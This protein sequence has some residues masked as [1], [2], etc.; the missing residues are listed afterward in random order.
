MIKKILAAALAAVCLIGTG[1][2][3]YKQM[4]IE[5]GETKALYFLFQ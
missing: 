4:P 5:T 1:C 2:D 3:Y